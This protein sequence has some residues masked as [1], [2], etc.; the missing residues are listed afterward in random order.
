MSGLGIQQDAFPGATKAELDLF[1]RMLFSCLVDADRLDSP[2]ARLHERCAP[3]ERLQTLVKH[4]D[5][6]E[7]FT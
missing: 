1:I 4:T 7:R 5:A 6:P 2:A 3:D